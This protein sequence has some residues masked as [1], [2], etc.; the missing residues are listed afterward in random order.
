MFLH[1]GVKE[2]EETIQ[3]VDVLCLYPWLYKYFKSPVG[4][5]TIHLECGD[6]LAILT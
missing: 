3:Y 6:L 2:C 4:H 5:S 1:Y